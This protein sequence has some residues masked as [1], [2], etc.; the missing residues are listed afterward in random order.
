LPVSINGCCSHTRRSDG[1]MESLELVHGDVCGPI[2]LV[3]PRGNHFFLL[4]V[5]YYSR[6][7]WVVLFP[8]KDG[9]STAI[10]NAQAAAEWKSGKQLCALRTDRRGEFMASHFKEYFTELGVQCQLTVSYSPPQN[11]VIERRNQIVVGVAWSMLKVKDLPGTFWREVV[12]T[13]VYIL[14][15]STSKG[16]DSKMPY[17]LWTGSTSSVNHLHTFGCVAYVKNVR[18]HLQKLE[19]RSKPMIF[20]GYEAGSM[21]YQAYDPVTKRVFIT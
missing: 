19:D 1:T 5:I 11:G 9:A 8:T 15:Q 18:P 7:M 13:A 3:T 21:A 20:V 10:K 17:E 14:N 12:A 6:Y 2:S 4:L 16:I